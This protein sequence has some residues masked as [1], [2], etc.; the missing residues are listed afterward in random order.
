[1]IYFHCSLLQGTINEFSQYMPVI[2][3]LSSNHLLI[4]HRYIYIISLT[5]FHAFQQIRVCSTLNEKLARYV[6]EFVE[7]FLTFSKLINGIFNSWH[8][9]NSPQVTRPL[10]L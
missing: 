2:V 3:G 10:Y 1:M 8:T 4:S 5:N 9:E 6:K 7:I